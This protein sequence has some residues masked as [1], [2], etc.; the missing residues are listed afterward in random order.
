MQ[1]R[2]PVTPW[3]LERFIAKVGESVVGNTISCVIYQSG[4]CRKLKEG[5]HSGMKAIR[6]CI[7]LW[8]SLQRDLKSIRWIFWSGPVE[9]HALIPKRICDLKWGCSQPIPTTWQRFNS[10]GSRLRSIHQAVIATKGASINY[11]H[12]WGEYL[13]PYCVLFNSHYFVEISFTLTFK[14]GEGYI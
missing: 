10:L 2:D 4:C 13:C 7:T 11:W 9:V 12:K 1:P 3:E 14:R 8:T 6:S 5:S